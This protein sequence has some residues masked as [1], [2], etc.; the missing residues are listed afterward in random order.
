MHLSDSTS[1]KHRSKEELGG[2]AHKDPTAPTPALLRDAEFA[3]PCGGAGMWLL[4]A[5]VWL[6]EDLTVVV[7]GCGFSLP[8]CGFV[9]T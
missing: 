8:V 4:L 9:R 2:L 5:R 7:L 3:A 6:C 1:F